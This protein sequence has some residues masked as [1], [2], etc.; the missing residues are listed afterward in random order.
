MP[1]GLCALLGMMAACETGGATE[2]GDEEAP[3]VI[4]S[5][6]EPEETNEGRD[7]Q[8]CGNVG[9]HCSFT[10]VRTVK[11]G[12]WDQFAVK[13]FDG[14]AHCSAASFGRDPAPGQTKWCFIDL[15]ETP[16]TGPIANDAGQTAPPDAGQTAPA[17]AGHH[18][19]GSGAQCPT[20]VGSLPAP[21]PGS[22]LSLI[23]TATQSPYQNDIGAFRI[24]CG[25]S[26]MNY[27]DPLVY[28]NQPGA[29][30]LHTFFGNTGTNAYSTATSIRNS[31]NSTCG[32]GIA[33]RSS[34]WMPT[35]LNNGVPM[36]PTSSIFYYKAGYGV[37]NASPLVQK[38]PAGLR[39]IAGSAGATALQTE[40]NVYWTCENN[41]NGEHPQIVDCAVGDS[42]Q[43]VIAFPQCWDGVRLDSSDHKSHMA[44]PS[45]D[46]CPSSHPVLLPQITFNVR[47]LRTA[48]LNLAA[49]KLSSDCQPSLP[50][51]YS[52][53]G[54]WVE[55]WEPSV[56]DTFVT[57]CINPNLDCEGYL[58]GDGR[59]LYDP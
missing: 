56:R 3:L 42:L 34:Y 2:A 17:D 57:R 22:G 16:G 18:G 40:G 5:A 10:G 36:V 46:A 7:W 49:L 54:D 35:L 32:G 43:M 27:D 47:W 59:E 24:P 31:G 8:F 21:R 12:T 11:F 30:H 6:I 55:G 4:R 58:L 15:N 28:P 38:I 52:V 19:G 37:S 33:N 14:G 51:G 44:Y 26:H 25:F 9:E 20:V 45:N 48:G 13:Y 53:H 39:M 1:V 50:G 29:A 23:R 41:Y